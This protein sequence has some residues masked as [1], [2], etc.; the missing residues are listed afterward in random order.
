[1]NGTHSPHHVF[2][3]LMGKAVEEL[4]LLEPLGVE[5]GYV[6]GHYDNMRGLS[7]RDGDESIQ[8]VLGLLHQDAH[9]TTRVKVHKILSENGGREMAMMPLRGLLDGVGMASPNADVYRTR[10]QT[11]KALESSWTPTSRILTHGVKEC[12]SQKLGRSTRRLTNRRFLRP[13]HPHLP[14][15]MDRESLP[16]RSQCS[17]PVSPPVLRASTTSTSPGWL[18]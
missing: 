6:R 3:G 14:K 4:A 5:R 16:F 8:R 18:T 1:M 2:H 11:T 17:C 15:S 7:N 9:N 10:A 12:I 13:T